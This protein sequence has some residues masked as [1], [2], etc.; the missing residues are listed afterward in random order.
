MSR[1][2]HASNPLHIRFA[3]FELDEANA[4]LWRHGEAVAAIRRVRDGDRATDCLRRTFREGLRA[5]AR[6]RCV[7]HQ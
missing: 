6:R 2:P 5:A 1:P 4:S 3:E 7:V